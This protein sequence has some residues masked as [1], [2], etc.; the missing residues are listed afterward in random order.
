MKLCIY[1]LDSSYISR[2]KFKKKLFI[3][4]FLYIISISPKF[5]RDGLNILE[6]FRNHMQ[7]IILIKSTQLSEKFKET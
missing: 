2:K 1:I 6:N 3:L 4:T 5:H 7:N